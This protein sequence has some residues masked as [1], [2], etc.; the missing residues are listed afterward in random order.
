MARLTSDLSELF[1][2]YHRL[3]DELKKRLEAIGYGI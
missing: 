1:A 3:E 2:Q